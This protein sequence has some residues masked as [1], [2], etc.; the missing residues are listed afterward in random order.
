MSNRE[1]VSN[2]LRG[3][4]YAMVRWSFFIFLAQRCLTLT[5]K[6]EE[7]TKREKDD[8]QERRDERFICEKF[9]DQFL[10]GA[11]EGADGLVKLRNKIVHDICDM[12]MSSGINDE[13]VEKGGLP[14]DDKHLEKLTGALECFTDVVGVFTSAA[15]ETLGNI[16]SAQGMRQTVDIAQQFV[17]AEKLRLAAEDCMRR[18]SRESGNGSEG[19]E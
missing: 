3:Y 11:K 10:F 16:V 18:H 6:S 19:R 8:L 17:V 4:G 1:M 12:M 14:I 13:N 5:M 7:M 9:F 2:F 15:E